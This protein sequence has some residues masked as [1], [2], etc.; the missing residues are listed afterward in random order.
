[1]RRRAD[2]E[3]RGEEVVQ[4]EEQL[5]ADLV[6]EDHGVEEEDQGQGEGDLDLEVEEPEQ[7]LG[8]GGRD[9]GPG[10]VIEDI[11]EKVGQNQRRKKNDDQNPS[12]SQKTEL[13]IV[14]IQVS[15]AKT[16]QRNVFKNP[17]GLYDFCCF[18]LK[19]SFAFNLY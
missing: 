17:S 13:E 3:A 1:M 9:Q 12:Q 10:I 15:I 18:I 8:K 4:E 14:T 5:E 11:G 6:D 16:L 19:Y 7:D 2:L